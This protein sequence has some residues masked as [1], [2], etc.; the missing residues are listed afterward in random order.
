MLRRF[1]R[2][3]QL[4]VRLRQLGADRAAAIGLVDRATAG[5]GVGAPDVTIHGGRGPRSGYCMAPRSVA[6]S[7]LGESV[8]RAWEAAKGRRWPEAGMIRLGDPTSLGTIA[9][10]LG[11][12]SVHLLDPSSTPAHGKVWVA[13]FDDAAEAVAGIVGIA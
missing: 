3:P 5:L 4:I 1:S 6:T 9:H 12:H 7:A 10:E 13:R 2:D 8:V 11:H